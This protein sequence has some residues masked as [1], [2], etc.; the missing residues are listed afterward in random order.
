[1]SCE[2]VR[3]YSAPHTDIEK[4]NIIKYERA[5]KLPTGQICIVM[6]LAANDLYT[7]LEARKNSKRRPYLSLGCIQSIGHQALSGLEYA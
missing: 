1:L 5:F 3:A 2:L 7:H 4:E 6:E